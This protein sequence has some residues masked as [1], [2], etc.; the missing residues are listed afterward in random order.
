MRTLKITSVFVSLIVLTLAACSKD[1]SEINENPNNVSETHPQLLLTQVAYN[2]F[3]VEGTGPMYAGRML[4]QT[5][6]ENNGQYYNWDRAS[7]GEYGDLR[8]VT[9][10]MEE[11]QRIESDTYIALAKFFRAYYFYKL[12]LTFGDIPYSEAL[13]G[14]NTNIFLP[15][16]DTQKQ[17]FQGILK[18]LEEANALLASGAE[19]IAGDIIFNGDPA[20]WRKLINSYRL[21]VLMTLSKQE[22]DADL[23]IAAAFAS[24]YSGQPIM[25]SLDDN[26]QLEFI[27]QDGSRYSQFNSSSYGSGMYMDSTFI[28]KLQDH[29]D[30]RL[31]IFCSTTKNAKEAGLLDDDFNAYEGGNPIAP[32][33]EVNDKAAAGDASKVNARYT[34]DPVA[35]PHNVL[36]YWE[37][38]F[39]LAEAAS[40]GWISEDAKEHYENGVKAS[41]AFY[42]SNARDA[43]G[44]N[45]YASFVDE[46]KAD[47]YLLE[48]LVNWD[49]ATTLEEQLELI[50]TQKYFTS[51]HQTGWR[52]YFE[53]LRTGY[54]EFLIPDSGTPPTRWI[55]PQSEYNQNTE[56]VSAAIERQFGSNNDGIR[57]VPWW[58][59]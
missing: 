24:I 42:Q 46:S 12:T 43:T 15:A 11:A 47:A 23:N 44:V 2:A 30:P 50:I 36:G 38:E 7:F 20:K 25:T 6:G 41:F 58:L 34:D 19:L 56:N 57:Q 49:N 27:D 10:L 9:K 39:I 3:G 4:V 55:Y 53:H 51:F 31:F 37:V 29:M 54:P 13:Q 8:N 17:V 28:K 48:D 16:Y 35:E 33:G 40:R 14:E 1:L 32:Y 52:M 45:D 59:Q 5:D 18:E 21:K 22:S 26:A